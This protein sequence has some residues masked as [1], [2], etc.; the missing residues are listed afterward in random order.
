MEKSG[1]KLFDQIS[2]MP[3]LEYD[4]IKDEATNFFTSYFS[5]E[6]SCE[7]FKDSLGRVF[8]QIIQAV[9][10]PE[11][12]DE[13]LCVTHL[14]ELYP[15]WLELKA[16]VARSDMHAQLASLSVLIN[17]TLGIES[18]CLDYNMLGDNPMI[19]PNTTVC[20]NDVHIILTAYLDIEQQMTAPKKDWLKLA[21]DV[22]QLT[23]Y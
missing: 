14:Q 9:T 13:D 17:S 5:A 12:A 2:N 7:V 4:L 23:V 21:Q 6:T 8:Y 11:A 1:I 19:V 22:L 20:K 3:I 15:A 16:A 18:N 10:L